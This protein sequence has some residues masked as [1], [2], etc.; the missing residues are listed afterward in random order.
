MHQLIHIFLLGVVYS[1]SHQGINITLVLAPL[2][3]N[4]GAKW[5]EICTAFFLF[6][7]TQR[8]AGPVVIIIMFV[9]WLGSQ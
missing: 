9:R 2:Q 8:Y 3:V 5:V 4:L 7:H 6:Y 1:V